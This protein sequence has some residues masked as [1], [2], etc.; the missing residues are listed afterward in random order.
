MGTCVGRGPAWSPS[1]GSVFAVYWVSFRS[2]Q[3]SDS[4]LELI[5]CRPKAFDFFL[6]RQD[7]IVAV[8]LDSIGIILRPIKL[9]LKLI[10][11]PVG[12]LISDVH[13]LRVCEASLGRSFPVCDNG[14]NDGSRDADPLSK[15]NWIHLM[16]LPSGP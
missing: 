15:L 10:D 2:L 9:F 16:A 7:L 1:E 12:R 5:N 6:V 11:R 8:I 3:L 14:C 4:F 13:R